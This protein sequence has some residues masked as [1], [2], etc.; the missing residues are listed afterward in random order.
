MVVTT[1]L[2]HFRRRTEGQERVIG[3]L[4]GYKT[5]G[6]IEM[7]QAFPIPHSE[8]NEIAVGKDIMKELLYLHKQ[9]NSAEK[10]VGWYATRQKEC[11]FDEKISLLQDFFE[12]EGKNPLHL[13]V[14]LFGDMK[15][16]AFSCKSIEEKKEVVVAD[17]DEVKVETVVD[18]LTKSFLCL[19]SEHKST[20]SSAIDSLDTS[21][22]KAKEMLK[23][24]EVDMITKKEIQNILA[25]MPSSDEQEFAQSFNKG[26]HDLL[27]VS[28]LTNLTKAQ[29]AISEKLSR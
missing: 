29:L 10:V 14:D 26:L 27:M 22:S 3:I 25:K 8:E 12:T 21:V 2:D 7:T 28:Y 15:V 19:D 23:S 24:N 20:L 5:N 13:Q 11:D 17:F 18:E 6:T 4:V 16:R 1:I 9:T